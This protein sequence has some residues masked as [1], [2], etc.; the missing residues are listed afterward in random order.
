MIILWI[1]IGIGL[2]LTVACLNDVRRGRPTW[3]NRR[4]HELAPTTASAA[5]SAKAG[6]ATTIAM[7]AFFGM[8]GDG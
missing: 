7:G 3:G 8:G 5:K 2:L 6:I 4:P 1:V